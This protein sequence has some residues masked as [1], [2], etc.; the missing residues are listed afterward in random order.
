M[1]ERE[2]LGLAF[3]KTQQTF[4]LF[5]NSNDFFIATLPGE[6]VYAYNLHLNANGKPKCEKE[7]KRVKCKKKKLTIIVFH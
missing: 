6:S 2:W 1:S 5:A 7:E 4:I 3:L